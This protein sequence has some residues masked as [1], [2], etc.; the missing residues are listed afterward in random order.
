MK[1]VYP[2]TFIHSPSSLYNPNHHKKRKVPVFPETFLQCPT[3]NHLMQ[4]QKRNKRNLGNDTDVDRN[5]S[6]SLYLCHFDLWHFH[7]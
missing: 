5:L 7:H 6:Y 2:I 4:Y 3:I 1:H